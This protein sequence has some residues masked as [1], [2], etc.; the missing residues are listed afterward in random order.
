MFLKG[1][2]RFEKACKDLIEQWGIAEQRIK[3]AEQVCANEIVSPA[4]FELRYAGRKI[5]DT[6]KVSLECDLAVDVEAKEL[7]YRN[8]IDAIEDCIK[9]KHDAIDAMVGFVTTW[10]DGVEKRL[11]FSAIQKIFPEYAKITGSI[12]GVLEKIAQSRRDRNAARDGVYDE[13]FREDFE[14]ILTLYQ[15]MKAS[16]SRFEAE[17]NH[18][19]MMG[20]RNQHL[21]YTGIAL[22]VVSIILA[23][24]FGVRSELD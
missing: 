8:L 2:P 23:I 3:R 13:I 11:G 14:K 20:K 19:I 4:I 24:I 10:F 17:V 12:S 1:D 9:A 21:A 7:A 15:T 5:I 18:E 22:A 16:Q 6:L